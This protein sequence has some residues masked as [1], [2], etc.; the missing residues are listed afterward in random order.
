MPKEKRNN[1]AIY[2]LAGSILLSSV[3]ISMSQGNAHS[4]NATKREFTALKSCI[5]NFH[6]ETQELEET[7]QEL[8]KGGEDFSDKVTVAVQ[9]YGEGQYWNWIGD[10]LKC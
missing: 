2:T 8:Q 3:L 4:T 5:V 10:K 6:R 1:L 9:A 7:F